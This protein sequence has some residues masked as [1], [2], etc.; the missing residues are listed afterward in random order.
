MYLYGCS[1]QTMHDF[2]N[3][4]QAYFENYG[5]R[6]HLLKIGYNE[7]SFTKLKGCHCNLPYYLYCTPKLLICLIHTPI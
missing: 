3:P 6:C 4:F 5:I 7:F 2:P 1:P